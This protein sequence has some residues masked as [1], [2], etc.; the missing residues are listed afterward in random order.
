MHNYPLDIRVIIEYT[1]KYGYWT[2]KLRPMWQTR[3]CYRERCRAWWWRSICAEMQELW[4]D[5]WA[6]WR[7]SGVSPLRRPNQFGQWA[8]GAVIIK[9]LF[10]K[11]SSDFSDKELICVGCREDFT[12]TSGEQEFMSGLLED[13]KINQIITPRRCKPC[14]EKSKQER[15]SR[16]Q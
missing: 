6:S 4:L 14:R 5:W 8:R 7:L 3:H 15:E 12:W 11:M 16:D 1:A 2:E 13:G 10:S 9:K